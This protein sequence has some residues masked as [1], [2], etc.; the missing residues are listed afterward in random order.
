MKKIVKALV[1]AL[2]LFIG[3]V[4]LTACSKG[5]DSNSIVGSWKNDDDYTNC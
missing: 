2:V 4:S 1:V 5:G 3:I